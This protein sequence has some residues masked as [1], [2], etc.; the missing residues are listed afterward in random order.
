MYV[1][2]VNSQALVPEAWE[3]YTTP[4][5]EPLTIGYAEVGENQDRWLQQWST[6]FR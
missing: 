2:P 4:V 5:P 3:K 1:F 6:L